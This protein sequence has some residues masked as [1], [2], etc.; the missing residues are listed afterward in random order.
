MF[1]LEV[2]RVGATDISD[3]DRRSPVSGSSAFLNRLALDILRKESSYKTVTA[4][5]GVD[6]LFIGNRVD[7][8]V[9]Y[10]VEL[11]F[12]VVEPGDMD[13]VLSAGD[14][15]DSVQGS[16]HFVDC[17]GSFV[18]VSAGVLRKGLS[19]FI[20]TEYQMGLVRDFEHP[21]EEAFNHEDSAE[22]EGNSFIMFVEMLS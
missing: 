1:F 7:E 18:P 2:R 8:R 22:S 5:V 12:M 17:R 15:K 11:I 19:F 21:V 13:G 16:E 14:D 9:K 4:A 10:E 6:D 20:V 3:N